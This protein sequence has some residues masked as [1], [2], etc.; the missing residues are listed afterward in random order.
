MTAITPAVQ[1]N[2]TATSIQLNVYKDDAV[3]EI[4]S[5]NKTGNFLFA[6]FTTE[7]DD[8]SN[9]INIEVFRS[10]MQVIS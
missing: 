6:K 7:V 2:T 8:I 3:N 5:N 9:L 1:I 4:L 10:V